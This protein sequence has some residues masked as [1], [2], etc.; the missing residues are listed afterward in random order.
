MDAMGI[1]STTWAPKLFK[2]AMK[3]WFYSLS[4]SLVLSLS[5]LKTLY[6]RPLAETMSKRKPDEKQNK[7]EVEKSLLVRKQWYGDRQ[8]LVKKVLIDA[9]DICI[10][11][12]ALEWLELRP[13]FLGMIMMTSTV[14]SSVDI[15]R[16]VNPPS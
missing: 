15:W 2:E 5:S 3:F 6:A 1:W 4:F 11:A 13:D 14:L 12:T 10:P 7:S 8:D 16:R 9:C